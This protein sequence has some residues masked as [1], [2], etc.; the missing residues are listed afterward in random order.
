[1]KNDGYFYKNKIFVM[2]QDFAFR[3]LMFIEKL[4]QLQDEDIL[5][6]LEQILKISQEEDW[7]NDLTDT[8]KESIERGIQQLNEG[9]GETYETFQK[10]MEKKFK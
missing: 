1:M 5:L 3:K 2:T 4:T 8:E 9:K 10:R 6:V 7:A